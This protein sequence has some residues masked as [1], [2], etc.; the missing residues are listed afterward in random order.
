MAQHLE[1]GV[2]GGL[3][4]G[5]RQLQSPHAA[6]RGWAVA[7]LA[8]AWGA[9][10]RREAARANATLAKARNIRRRHQR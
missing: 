3:G 1:H 4:C 7:G 10:G 9:A 6:A 8:V 2:K 5:A